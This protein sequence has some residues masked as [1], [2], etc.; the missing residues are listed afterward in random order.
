M[1]KPAIGHVNKPIPST[2]LS[3]VQHE[4]PK[5]AGM[6][7][8]SEGYWCLQLQ[9]HT[10]QVPVLGLLDPQE[11]CIAFLQNIGNYL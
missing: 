3:T 2:S 4:Y 10:V 11:E 9:G 7:P 5:P 8:C 1:S 6:L